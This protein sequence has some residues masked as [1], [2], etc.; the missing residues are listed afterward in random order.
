MPTSDRPV[1]SHERASI[2]SY[3]QKALKR[4]G[5]DRASA[6]DPDRLQSLI[7]QAVDLYRK[8]DDALRTA[9][10]MDASVSL[11]S[12]WG[13]VICDQ[14]GWTW[15]AI[16]TDPLNLNY[17]V[18]SSNRSHIIYPLHFIKD[19][20]ADPAREQNSL[21]LYMQVRTGALPPANDHEY[22]LLGSNVS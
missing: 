7:S 11:G 17:A 4:I 2:T 22:S 13:Q 14:M 9:S 16:V 10:L 12:L 5:A 15:V 1:T 8:Q 6:P 18:V 3:I 19:L 21:A 20:L